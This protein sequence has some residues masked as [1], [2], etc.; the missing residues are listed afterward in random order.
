MTLSLSHLDVTGLNWIPHHFPNLLQ[1]HRPARLPILKDGF[2]GLNFSPPKSSIGS[3]CS[4]NTA[5]SLHFGTRVYSVWVQ[6]V[7]PL[8]SSNHSLSPALKQ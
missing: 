1:I 8:L 6:L 2:G 5:Q 4:P 7:F 3:N